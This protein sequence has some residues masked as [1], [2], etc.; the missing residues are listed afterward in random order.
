MIK[1]V[2]FDRAQR[3]SASLFV[4][5]RAVVDSESAARVLNAFRHHC[6]FHLRARR[7][8]SASASVLNAFR[9]HCSFHHVD[10]LPPRRRGQVLNAFR[11]HC[12][13]HEVNG[14]KIVGPMM[15][16]TPFGII[17]RSTL[18][19]LGEGTNRGGAQRLSASLFVP[20]QI[21][22]FL[23]MAANCA[24][25]LSASLFVPLRIAIGDY[26]IWRVLNAFRHHCSF[27]L[28]VMVNRGIFTCVLNAFRHHCS[29][30]A[31]A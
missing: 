23:N 15:C 29:F 20:H 12:S 21:S 6:S 26:L 31:S 8:A 27:H 17:V 9:H 13:F 18:G 22:H 11:H 4:P 28:I 7:H 10:G 14:R 5:P 19:G 16:S 1:R 24:Q 3:L 30:H 25:R 2:P